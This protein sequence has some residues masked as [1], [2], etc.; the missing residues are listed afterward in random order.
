MCPKTIKWRRS[1]IHV[2]KTNEKKHEYQIP[3][4]LSEN[5]LV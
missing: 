1:T 4:K 5:F 3:E 2:Q